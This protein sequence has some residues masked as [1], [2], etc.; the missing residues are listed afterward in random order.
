MIAV[1]DVIIVVIAVIDMIFNISLL[2]I[3]CPFSHSR[4][5]WES[6]DSQITHEL[7]STGTSLVG[8]TKW[9]LQCSSVEEW[10]SLADS[11]RGSRNPND[12]ALLA[13]LDEQFLDTIPQMIESKV[14][15]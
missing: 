9:C 10:N 6:Q 8:E 2:I 1:I 15:D 14:C 11:L 13:A 7:N 5:D 12:K 3:S 4:S